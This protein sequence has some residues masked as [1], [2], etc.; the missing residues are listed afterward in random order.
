MKGDTR[1]LDYS[2]YRVWDVWGLSSIPELGLVA[3]VGHFVIEKFG[4][5]V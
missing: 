3:G 1:S 2:S 4:R 5:G